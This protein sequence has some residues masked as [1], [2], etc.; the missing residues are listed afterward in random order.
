MNCRYSSISATNTNT[1]VHWN[2]KWFL[3]IF[4][5]GPF[6][7][8]HLSFSWCQFIINSSNLFWGANRGHLHCDSS[9]AVIR[10]MGRDKAQAHWYRDAARE[11]KD[12]DVVKAPEISSC[13]QNDI[14]ISLYFKHM[15]TQVCVHAGTYSLHIC[16]KNKLL[17]WNSFTV[18]SEMELCSLPV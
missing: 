11:T 2:V 9:L 1:H 14:H 18:S 3:I 13:L 17:W 16:H 5:Y 15:H 8:A 4:R 10:N 7:Y 6:L 12:G